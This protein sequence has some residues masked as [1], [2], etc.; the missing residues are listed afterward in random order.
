MRG[1]L[2]FFPVTDAE[3]RDEAFCIDKDKNVVGN[4][5]SIIKVIIEHFHWEPACITGGLFWDR[6]DWNGVLF[7]N[8]HIK[9]IN[10]KK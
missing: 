7:W 5:E 2:P 9:E 8:D 6:Q 10:P 1:D 3:G 4:I